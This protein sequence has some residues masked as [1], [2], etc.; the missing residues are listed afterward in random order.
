MVARWSDQV[1]SRSISVSR[2]SELGGV[3]NGRCLGNQSR[4]ESRLER[5][6]PD[7]VETGEGVT[8]G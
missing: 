5:P 1:G 7:R 6:V 8:R 4:V 2:G 3:K